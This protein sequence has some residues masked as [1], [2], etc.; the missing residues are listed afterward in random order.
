MRIDGRARNGKKSGIRCGL[1]NLQ[2]ESTIELLTCSK[3]DKTFSNESVE[4]IPASCNGSDAIIL[5][6]FTTTKPP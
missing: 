6:D 4:I 1:E 2:P 3:L 5:P